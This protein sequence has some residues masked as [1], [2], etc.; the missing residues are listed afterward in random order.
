M[1][2]KDFAVK[3]NIGRGAFANVFSAV[4]KDGKEVSVTERW[5]WR[6]GCGHVTQMSR[7]I[8]ID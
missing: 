3:E 1:D 4:Y 8:I 2:T 6:G 5:V 7:H